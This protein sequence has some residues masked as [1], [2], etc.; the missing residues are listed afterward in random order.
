MVTSR[1][2][3]T[4]NLWVCIRDVGTPFVSF[5][6]GYDG[7]IDLVPPSYPLIMGKR[8][9]WFG[10]PSYSFA[11]GKRECRFGTPSYPFTRGK[12]EVSI[13]YPPNT[14]S[15]GVREWYWFWTPSYPFARSK[16]VVPI[17]DPPYSFTM[18]KRGFEC[19]ALCVCILT[20]VSSLWLPT[21]EIM[22]HTFVHFRP[23]KYNNI[24]FTFL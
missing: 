13:W 6:Y 7:G 8:G 2:L 4:P 20:N 11:R 15:L 21:P 10:T 16:R 23:T 9:Y 14:R 17:W 5:R 19:C 1:V 24:S 12:R 18:G 22:N 3:V